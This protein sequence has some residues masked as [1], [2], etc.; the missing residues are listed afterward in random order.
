V[1]VRIVSD[2]SV[3]CD[4]LRP[5]ARVPLR[6]SAND[7]FAAIAVRTHYVP[8]GQDYFFFRRMLRTITS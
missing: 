2:L 7:V 3:C 4:H 6:T 8:L 5:F 1:I